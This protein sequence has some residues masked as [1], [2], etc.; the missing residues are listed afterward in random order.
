VLFEEARAELALIDHGF[1]FAREHDLRHAAI[2][3]EWRTRAGLVDLVEEELA[4][5]ELLLGDDELLG[6]RRYLDP[7]RAEALAQRAGA[8]HQSRRLV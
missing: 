8:T 4:A 1:A 3:V 5:L 2:L 6:L 7:D